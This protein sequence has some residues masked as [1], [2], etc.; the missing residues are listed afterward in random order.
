MG[1]AS[2]HPGYIYAFLGTP[3]TILVIKQ[4]RG[5]HQFEKCTVQ[6]ASYP[7]LPYSVRRV[8]VTGSLSGADG[9][10][11]VY[12]TCMCVSVYTDVGHISYM[13]IAEVI[14]PAAPNQP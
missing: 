3:T 10:T 13:E 2:I 4:S 14:P 9:Q 8:K 7:I 12:C 1:V 6:L 5:S 11:Y